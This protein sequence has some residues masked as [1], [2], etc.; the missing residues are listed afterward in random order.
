VSRRKLR[1]GIEYALL[2][3]VLPAS[4]AL[5]V[6]PLR[7][8][9]ALWLLA[10]GCLIVLLRDPEFDRRR[11]WNAQRLGPRFRR[12]ALPF[13]A[14]APVLAGATA[15][16][17]PERLFEFV[18]REP[19]LWLVVMLLYPLLSA[20]PQ[21]VVYRA[22]V[23]HRY[24]E[25]LPQRWALILASAL[26][27]S[28]VHVVFRNWVAPVLSL[29]GGALFAWTYE[30]TGSSLVATLQHALFG[31]FLFTIGLGWYFYQGAI[32]GRG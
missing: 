18:R 2:F 1:L 6:I 23:V 30:R 22:F 24:R 15:A 12:A 13:L 19:L 25:L 7:P 5:R 3:A 21:G 11:L 14:A 20:Y 16:W 8:I 29:F 9:P 31:C 28:L 32:P 17:A 4:Y 10:G 26:A 27:F